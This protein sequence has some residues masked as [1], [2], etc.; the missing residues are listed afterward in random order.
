MK[1]E[2]YNYSHI[3]ALLGYYFVVFLLP[4]T[5]IPLGSTSVKGQAT[6]LALTLHSKHIHNIWKIFLT[7]DLEQPCIVIPFS[8]FFFFT[9]FNTLFMP[10]L[11]CCSSEDKALMVVKDPI[12]LRPPPSCQPPVNRTKC[13]E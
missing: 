10:F 13:L 5:Q 7:D 4:V 2:G 8:F 12:F 1:I 9:S 11:L 3:E 6:M